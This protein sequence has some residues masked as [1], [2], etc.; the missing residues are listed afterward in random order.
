MRSYSMDLGEV[1]TTVTTGFVTKHEH[2]SRSWNDT[3]VRT[4]QRR[5][6]M[7]LGTWNVSSLYRLGSLTAAVRELARYT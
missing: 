2:L 5:G 7:R 4:T 3:F 1:L 6:D